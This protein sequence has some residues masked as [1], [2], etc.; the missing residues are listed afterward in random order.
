MPRPA[1]LDSTAIMRINE[2][3]QMKVLAELADEHEH[4]APAMGGGT[5]AFMQGTHWLC[6]AIGCNIDS[7]LTL[8]GARH[9][10]EYV[11]S[12]GGRPR[13]DLTD[14]AGKDAFKV[15]ARVGL[16]L[17]HAERVLARD[18]AQP[19]EMPD[20]P[21]LTIERLDITDQDALDRHARFTI[22]G[23][24][25]PGQAMSEGEVESAKRAQ[26]HPRS[27][28]FSAFIDGQ[29]AATCGMEVISIAPFP[30][31]EL[32]LVASLWGAV[33][34]EQF[35]RRGLQQALIA[36]RLKQGV[37]EG[38]TVAVIECEPGI[39]TERNST[40]AGFGLAYTRL[41]FKAPASEGSPEQIG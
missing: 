41:A 23:F 38:C 24:T 1:Q 3:R 37:A 26:R 22:G 13:I 27:R 5:V 7:P 33:V 2:G 11:D 30:G 32:V 10:Y 14:Q 12:R 35:R 15:V 4:I 9:I 31:D 18:L 34:G 8:E 28:G 16:Q 6:G 36:Q 17:E 25:P 40:R 20:V 19:I 29:F 39:P 21:G